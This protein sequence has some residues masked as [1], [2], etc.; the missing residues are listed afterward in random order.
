[1]IG[2]KDDVKAELEKIASQGKGPALARFALA[3]IGGAVPL[4]G[5]VFSG[6]GGAWSEA[7][8]SKFKKILIA[9]LKLQEEEIIEI[10]KTLT[11]VLLKIDTNNEEILR[12]IESSEYLSLIKKCFRDWSAAE[13][14]YKRGLVRNLLIAS[15]NSKLC[16]D[17]VIRMFIK[18]IDQ[19]DESHFKVIKAV[20]HNPGATRNEIWS[21]I[22][23]A[24]VRE[25]SAEADL[26]KLLVSDL[27]IG[28]IIRQHRE[29]DYQGNFLKVRSQKSNYK[30]STM[31]SAFDDE[32]QYELTELGGQFVHYT[33]NEEVAKIEHKDL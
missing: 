31:T 25:D 28:R 1:M 8:E 6:S 4:A 18:W 22:H 10:G 26:F 3:V 21:E 7:D 33:M 24:D 5:G 29:K 23:G 19:Y 16:S 27:S 30:R 2:S 32:K 15:A 9:W 11:E 17:D 13:S 20:Y 12:R 14:E